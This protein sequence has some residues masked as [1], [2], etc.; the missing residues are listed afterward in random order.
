M[1]FVASYVGNDSLIVTSAVGDMLIAVVTVDSY[2]TGGSVVADPLP[3]LQTPS[4]WTLLSKR[5]FLYP[6]TSSPLA[7]MASIWRATHPQEGAVY[8]MSMSA[9]TSGT[10]P[11]RFGADTS[12][13]IITSTVLRYSG[14]S[15]V[16][17]VQGARIFGKADAFPAAWQQGP[18]T[19][20]HVSYGDGIITAPSNDSARVS[21]GNPGISDLTI[22]GTTSPPGFVANAPSGIST[23][24]LQT[25]VLLAYPP[26]PT[27]VLDPPISS[28]VDC[29]SLWSVSWD[30]IAGQSAY[31]I[32]RTQDG[33][34]A[35]YWSGSA[36]QSTQAWV[37]SQESTVA[38]SGWALGSTWS[39]AVAVQTAAT[40]TLS[41]QWS[42]A[43]FIGRATP[44]AP[45]MTLS[46]TTVR[47]PTVTLSGSAASG[48]ILTGWSVT[49]TQASGTQTVTSA[50]SPVQLPRLDDGPLT[51]TARVVQN[52]DQLGAS[53]T[54]TWTIAVAPI[55][56]PV[57]SVH[58]IKNIA[59]GLGGYELAVSTAMPSG[60]LL[61]VRRDGQLV[62]DTTINTSVLMDDFV[63][64]GSYSARI[65][66]DPQDDDWS[67][68]ATVAT[69]GS[70]DHAQWLIDDTDPTA[71][72]F[73]LAL[74]EDKGL[75]TDLR[76]T[77][78]A[79]IDS[80]SQHVQ[81]LTAL[82]PSG[83]TTLLV[84]DAATLPKVR[85]LLT[86]GRRLRYKWPESQSGVVG[87]TDLFRVT[88]FSEPRVASTINV[89]AWQITYAWVSQ[90]ND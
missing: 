65:G 52:G 86:S 85:S 35:Q 19:V 62:L 47:R 31:S 60:S 38:M 84:Q 2:P 32:R 27:P 66:D 1:S 40:G 26:I 41:S 17:E 63:E 42:S 49:A 61:Q 73:L 44:A 80:P 21:D 14:L 25:V 34:A 70:V 57:V 81:Q 58:Q 11:I 36:W 53:A 69:G 16:A 89:D 20:L 28:S 10:G 56:K 46:S 87:R 83:Q 54:G 64:A 76:A 24:W 9:T 90:P 51:V 50:T 67:D 12:G 77:V 59:S 37:S 5:S 79:W 55:P 22:S 15:Y 18:S 30:P 68:W 82:D 71:A 88:S 72:V 4:G 78:T 7:S 33:G 48:A 8:I 29:L 45:T 3:S 43:S 74:D 13:V 23:G 6:T 75:V 39:V